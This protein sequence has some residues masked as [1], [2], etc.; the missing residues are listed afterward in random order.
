MQPRRPAVSNCWVNSPHPSAAASITCGEFEAMS[1]GKPQADKIVRAQRQIERRK[2]GIGQHHF[3]EC[4][5]R[6]IRCQITS[7]RRLKASGL[8]ARK[9]DFTRKVQTGNKPDR[10]ARE[11]DANHAPPAHESVVQNQRQHQAQRSHAIQQVI[12][13][14]RR[15]QSD[16]ERQKYRDRK[17]QQRRSLYAPTPDAWRLR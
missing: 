7:S 15:R 16:F 4:F 6:A 1:S 3:E 14:E 9:R 8:G 12:R 10:K 17:L 11:R 2:H 5:S 13:F